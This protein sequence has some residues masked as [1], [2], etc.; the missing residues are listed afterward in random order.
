[1][2][3]HPIF[4]RHLFDWY[5]WVKG[6][7]NSQYLMFAVHWENTTSRFNNSQW[8]LPTFLLEPLIFIYCFG[9][10]W[11]DGIY[12]KHYVLDFNHY[13]YLCLQIDIHQWRINIQHSMFP[14]FPTLHWID[15]YKWVRN[16]R[17]S[18]NSMLDFHWEIT[19]VL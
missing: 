14:P 13:G 7:W 8:I 6:G 16:V 2:L 1:M 4:S 17:K 15:T 11:I 3:A 9:Y 18:Q 12:I 10:W 19:T 5:I